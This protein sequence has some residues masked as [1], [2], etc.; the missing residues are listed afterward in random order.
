ME[1][2]GWR[3]LGD[4]SAL[5]EDRILHLIHRT[6]PEYTVAGA[7]ASCR[8]LYKFY[9]SVEPG[10][11]VIARRGRKEVAA[12]GRVKRA[13]YFDPN[14]NVGAHDPDSAYPNH[15]DVQWA[16]APR[17]TQFATQVFG[18][19]TIHEISEH[20]F[21]TLMDA[22][23]SETVQLH[24]QNGYSANDS[25]KTQVGGA[26]MNVTDNH[27]EEFE[28]LMED[29]ATQH[30]TESPEEFG[31]EKRKIFTDKSDPPIGALCMKYEAGD[32]VLDPIFQRR[33]VWED[34]RSSRLIESVILEVPLPVFYLA[35]ESDGK[36]E[37]IDGQQRLNAF[38]RFLHNEYSLTGSR[39][40]P[41]LTASISRTSIS[42][43]RR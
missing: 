19:Q 25:P 43:S 39:R 30:E 2:I 41:T 20:K 29:E 37:V 33:K 34:S 6:Y 18:M 7:K 16:D 10:D 21:R 32:L 5:T 28:E 3:A 1:G 12:I 42:L 31:V 9:H 35:E 26:F 22:T 27:D 13:A 4:V 38:F 8:M 11:I 15:L 23:V 24:L 36:E 40:F 17:D 14:K